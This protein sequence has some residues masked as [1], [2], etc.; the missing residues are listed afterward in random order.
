VLGSIAEGRPFA[1]GNDRRLVVL[2]ATVAVAG[3]LAPL[4]PQLAGLLVLDR[5]GLAGPRFMATPSVELAPLLVGV[6]ILAAAAAFRAGERLAD[7]VR[8]LV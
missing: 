3:V 7:D 8:G 6:L 2:A 5:T 1:R 4:L